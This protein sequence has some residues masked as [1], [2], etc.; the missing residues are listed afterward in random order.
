M[1][2]LVQNEIRPNL[3]TW[4]SLM[5]NMMSYSQATF[6]E[7]R[8]ICIKYGGD[9]KVGIKNFLYIFHLYGWSFKLEIIVK[10]CK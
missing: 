3:R 7:A 4:I 8:F 6:N 10:I 1:L 9:R 2:W 5:D